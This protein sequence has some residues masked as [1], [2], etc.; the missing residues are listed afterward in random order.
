M[1][2]RNHNELCIVTVSFLK[3]FSCCKQKVTSRGLI[4][5][6]FNSFV[7]LAMFET[8]VHLKNINCTTNICKTLKTFIFEMTD[9]FSKCNKIKNKYGK[10]Q[11]LHRYL[12]VSYCTNIIIRKHSKLLT[13]F[14]DRIA[15]SSTVSAA[16]YFP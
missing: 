9:L 16:L 5:F 2:F 14:F 12:K 11:I 8:L 4:F 3:H 13:F 1:T 15:H 10:N 7:Q 6:V